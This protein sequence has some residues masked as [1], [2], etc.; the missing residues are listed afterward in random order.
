[1]EFCSPKVSQRHSGERGFGTEL[2]KLLQL[3]GSQWRDD[4]QNLNLKPMWQDL[5]LLQRLCQSSVYVCRR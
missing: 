2:L 4:L 1:M 3:F 5:L